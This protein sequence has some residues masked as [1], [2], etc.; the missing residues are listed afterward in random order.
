MKVFISKLLSV[1]FVGSVTFWWE[2]WSKHLFRT[3]LGFSLG[4]NLSILRGES[5]WS[6]L[7]LRSAVYA[8]LV[9]QLYFCLI[10]NNPYF[11]SMLQ[12]WLLNI[13]LAYLR[14]ELSKVI[15]ICV[16][17][18]AF[19]WRK[20]NLI[21]CPMYLFRGVHECN[22]SSYVFNSRRI[23]IFRYIFTPYLVQPHKRIIN[24]L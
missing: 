17:G 20:I 23:F 6:M 24:D 22:W 5:D 13:G 3:L 4:T 14:S 18:Y 2:I 7:W 9:E 19:L 1:I 21:N 10:W 8:T 16:T 11:L 12:L 15:L